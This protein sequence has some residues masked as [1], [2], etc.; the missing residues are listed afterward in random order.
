MVKLIPS[1]TGQRTDQWI[2]HYWVDDMDQILVA[3][4]GELANWPANTNN[5][6]GIISQQFSE[7]IIDNCAYSIFTG[8]LPDTITPMDRM[9]AQLKL[10]KYT[11]AEKVT[12]VVPD[13]VQDPAR[14]MKAYKELLP[15][16]RT[17]THPRLTLMFVLQGDLSDMRDMYQWIKAQNFPHYDIAVATQERGFDDLRAILPLV[18]SIPQRVH[19]FGETRERAVAMFEGIADSYD[20]SA[21]YW[22]AYHQGFRGA[23]LFYQVAQNIAKSLDSDFRPFTP[24]QS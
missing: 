11:V 15:F 22:K 24:K 5:T 2:N 13:F 19:L 8:K 10:A 23:E 4:Y 7:V 14:T 20:T 18:R 17:L 21:N 6:I 9:V 1:V 12:L 3:P 16:L